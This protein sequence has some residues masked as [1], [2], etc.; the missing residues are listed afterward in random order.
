MRF[1]IKIIT[2][3][4]FVAIFLIDLTIG[5]QQFIPQAVSKSSI[6]VFLWFCYIYLSN[7]SPVLHKKD[8]L[9]AV[10]WVYIIF[11]LFRLINDFVLNGVDFFMYKSPVTLLFF[12]FNLIIIPCFFYQRYR[13]NIDIVLLNRFLFIFLAFFLL[14]SIRDNLTGA[15]IATVNDRYTGYGGIDIIYYGHLGVSMIIIG[16]SIL[17]NSDNKISKFIIFPICCLIGFLSIVFSGS[18]GPFVAL[19]VVLLFKYLS[20]MKSL[21]T[22]MWFLFF[23]SLIALFYIDIFLGIN[24]ILL[25]FNITSFSRIAESVMFKM[26]AS[27]RDSLFS[28]A[29]NDFLDNPIFG[30]AYL[31]E[32]GGYVHNIILEQFRALGVVGGTL[33]LII[34]LVALKRAF[35]LLKKEPRYTLVSLLF[36]QYFIL[37][38]FSR[39]IVAIPQLWLCFFVLNNLYNAYTQDLRNNSYLQK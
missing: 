6:F 22:I 20:C 3:I 39:T 12:V 14:L 19:C 13:I 28:V 21:R 4:C 36:L 5:I 25:K 18:R 10:V 37:G 8:W 29:F 11:L 31:L 34:I 24:E 15:I 27:G 23:A 38:M 32:D 7:C 2:V 17:E 35:W 16:I 26:S 33:F 1:L 9:K 30:K